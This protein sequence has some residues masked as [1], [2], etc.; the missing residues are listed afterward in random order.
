MH[1]TNRFFQALLGVSFLITVIF[2]IQLTQSWLSYRSLTGR[3]DAKILS[4]E[5][6][7]SG[8]TFPLKARYRFEVGGAPV[9]GAFVFEQSQ[10]LNEA[11]AFEAM[12]QMAKERW[13]VWYEP[14]RPSHSVLIKTFPFALMGK[15]F[16]CF[17]VLLYFL[18]YQN[19]ITNRSE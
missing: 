2:S 10:Y 5:V 17:F 7:S 4:W 18:L 8:G 12:K 19:R 15:T 13:W 16:V 6:L 9:E 11:S 3:T 1:K 14:A